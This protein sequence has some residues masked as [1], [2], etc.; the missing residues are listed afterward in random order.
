MR[1]KLSHARVCNRFASRGSREIATL[2]NSGG[3]KRPRTASACSTVVVGILRFFFIS[4]R[5]V[6]AAC[7][8]ERQ[9]SS[10]TYKN[11]PSIPVQLARH[12][13]SNA[14]PKGCAILETTREQPGLKVKNAPARAGEVVVVGM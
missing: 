4:W 8:A 10:P 2:A 12:T 11:E 9:N 7:Q 5:Q 3:L 14:R 13:A 6:S 1:K